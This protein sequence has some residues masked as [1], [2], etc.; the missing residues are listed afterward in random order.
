[1]AY[2]YFLNNPSGK[3]T[4]DCVV[5]AVSLATGES[6][7]KTYIALAFQGFLMG[8]IMNADSVWGA[9]LRNNGMTMECLMPEGVAEMLNVILWV[10][11]LLITICVVIAAMQAKIICCQN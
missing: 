6:W 5:R 2:Q 10:D 3:M 4:G 9:Y 11:I 7:E 1:M 8:D